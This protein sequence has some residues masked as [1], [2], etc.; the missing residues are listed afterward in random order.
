MSTIHHVPFR[1]T[2]GPTTP[3]RSKGTIG[4]R[5]ARDPVATIDPEVFSTWVPPKSSV[6][7]MVEGSFPATAVEKKGG[8]GGNKRPGCWWGLITVNV[9]QKRGE[10]LH[11]TSSGNGTLGWNILELWIHVLFTTSW[12]VMRYTFAW[13]C[14]DGQKI[15]GEHVLAGHQL[16]KNSQV[17]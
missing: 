14:R 10:S 15:M 1:F 9:G 17:S 11:R 16:H 12:T 7:R 5:L 8:H 4:R 13:R 2:P 3:G 6:K